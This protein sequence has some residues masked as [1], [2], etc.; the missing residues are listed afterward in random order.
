MQNNKSNASNDLLAAECQKACSACCKK[1]KIFIP[2]AEHAAIKRWLAKNSPGDLKE[3]SMRSDERGSFFL[4]DQKDRC[5]FLDASELCRLHREGIKPRECFWWPLHAYVGDS[6]TVEIRVSTSCCPAYLQIN[7]ASPC[8]DSVE[9]DIR[10][11]GFDIVH[12][13]RQ[14]YPGS[15]SGVLLR[16]VLP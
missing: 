6:Q 13:F 11:L 8:L 15:Y 5:Q 12:E 1:G 3:F 4:Y 2:A 10:T 14:I 9:A 16:T 7:D